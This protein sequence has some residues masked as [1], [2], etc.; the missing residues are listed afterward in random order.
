MVKAIETKYGGCRFRSRTEARW[1]V[2]FDVV[3]LGW[4]YEK[5]GFELPSGRY[6]PD[7][8]LPEAKTWAEVKGGDFS[9]H[10]KALCRELAEA[11]GYRCLMLNGPPDEIFYWAA[12]PNDDFSPDRLMDYYLPYWLHEGRFYSC[13]GESYPT[14]A[15]NDFGGCPGVVA[16]KSARFE[17]GE[18]GL[19]RSKL[20][21]FVSHISRLEDRF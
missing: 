15:R 12:E 17:H 20:K 5:E 16:A 19:S 2:F 10:E 3:E 8:W 11:T 7:F 4:Q 6:L 14:Q 1:A 9:E 18:N 21:P 13:S